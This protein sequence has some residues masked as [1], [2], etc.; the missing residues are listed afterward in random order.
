ML[1]SLVLDGCMA[2]DGPRS[3]AADARPG[4]AN[5]ADASA[6]TEI[7]DLTQRAIAAYDRQ[8]KASCSCLVS[9][10][11]YPSE[12]ACMMLLGSGPSWAGCG[13]KLLAEHDGPESRGQINCFIESSE[14]Q[15]ECGNTA[16]CD[17][18]LAAMCSE[19]PAA[20]ANSEPSLVPQLLQRCP[21]L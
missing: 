1:T 3:D 9:A 6:A 4:T 18:R 21:D 8:I 10:G 12:Q 13:A 17:T 19:V 11:T 15:A 2:S 7:E 20:C 14:R 16:A 5:Q